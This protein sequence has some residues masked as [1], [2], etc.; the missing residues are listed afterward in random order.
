MGDAMIRL[1]LTHCFSLLW[2]GM[3][4]SSPAWAD[5]F[6]L[7]QG[8]VIQGEWQNPDESPR[9]T[10]RVKTSSGAMLNLKVGMVERVERKTELERRYEE[11]VRT[12]P[13]T[14]EA[15]LEIARRCAELGLKDRQQFHLAQVLRLQADHEEA[16]RLL[17]YTKVDGRWVTR[18]E[19]MA[20]RGYVR[21][22][23][24]WRLPQEVLLRHSSGELESTVVDYRKQLKNWRTI[25]ARGRDNAGPALAQIQAIRDPLAADALVELLGEEKEPQQLKLL[26]IEVLG[27]LDTPSATHAFVAHALAN[28]DMRVREACLDQICLDDPRQTTA[29]FVRKLQDADRT[30]VHRAAVALARIQDPTATRPLIDALVTKHKVLTGSGGGG[31]QPTFSNAGSG[32]SL[33]GGPKVEEKDFQ[34]EP[35]LKALTTLHPGV[36]YA[37]QQDQWRAWYAAE[38]TPRKVNLRRGD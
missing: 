1:T 10:Y 27:K 6:W 25:I 19:W 21:E 13:D 5:L 23:G 32:L 28:P 37:F 26:Y 4:L 9:T 38:N 7:T 15:H 20:G 29:V 35:V 33:G 24:T 14:V 34:N 22:G 12:L 16:R 31:I 30:I 3:I 8:G 18:E 17:G 2:V 36:N 11:R